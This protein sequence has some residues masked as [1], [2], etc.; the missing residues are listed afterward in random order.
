MNQPQNPT[1]PD[2]LTALP[3]EI[4]EDEPKF[5]DF[6]RFA[7]SEIQAAIEQGRALQKE[8]DVRKIEINQALARLNAT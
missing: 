6:L 2:E 7:T 8:I 3:G 4:S 5:R 1:V